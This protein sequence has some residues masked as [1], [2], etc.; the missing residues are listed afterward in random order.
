MSE[1]SKPSSPSK[2]KPFGEPTSPVKFRK[3]EPITF[4]DNSNI[5][6]CDFE[7]EKVADVFHPDFQVYR[8][9][10]EAAAE[11]SLASYQFAAPYPVGAS[12]QM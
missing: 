1:P 8:V 10:I 9:R 2:G 4:D 7:R 12:G 11:I 5:T 3:V 6:E